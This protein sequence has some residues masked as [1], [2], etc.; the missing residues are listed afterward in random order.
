VAVLVVF[1]A[2]F[3]PVLSRFVSVLFPV[4]PSFPARAIV[5]INPIFTHISTRAIL[6]VN[7][8][9]TNIATRAI[10]GQMAVLSGLFP[11]LSHFPTD[12]N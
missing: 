2:Q 3:C 10:L 8:S 12:I 11:V 7:P 9:F 5:G 4:L 6:G 1:F